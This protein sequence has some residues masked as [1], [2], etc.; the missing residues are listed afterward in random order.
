M[1][2]SG[3]SEKGI[4]RE[5]RKPNVDLRAGKK[6]PFIQDV[7]RTLFHTSFFLNLIELLM[8]V[9]VLVRIEYIIGLVK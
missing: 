2:M 5:Q 6:D 7:I 9:Y 8:L 1:S 4:P 3:Q